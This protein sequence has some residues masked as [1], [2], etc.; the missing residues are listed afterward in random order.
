[1]L[2]AEGVYEHIETIGCPLGFIPFD[3]DLF[4]LR[5]ESMFKSFFIV[6]SK[7]FFLTF[8]IYFTKKYYTISIYIKV[9]LLN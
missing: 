8:D 6:S 9:L 3:Y 4:I 5:Q 1:M 2:E 7:F